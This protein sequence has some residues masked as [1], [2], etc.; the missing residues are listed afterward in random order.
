MINHEEYDSCYYVGSV[1]PQTAIPNLANMN[2]D[3]SEMMKSMKPEQVHLAQYLLCD[4]FTIFQISSML[5]MVQENP[6]MID[7]IMAMSG[8]KLPPV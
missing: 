6:S 2:M 8:S 5:K 3:P 7:Q 1:A 4:S